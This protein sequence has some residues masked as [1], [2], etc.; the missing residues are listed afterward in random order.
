[1]SFARSLVL[2]VLISTL[3]V[4][5]AAAAQ[6]APERLTFT[7]RLVRSDGQPETGTHSLRFV[8]YDGPSSSAANLWEETR[9]VTI[10]N[11]Y[12]TV[13]LGAVALTPLSSVFTGPIRYLGLSLNQQ[14]EMQPRV[15]MLSTPYALHATRAVK[16]FDA[17]RATLA[18]AATTSTNATNAANADTLDT[19]DSSAFAL[20]GHGHAVATSTADG[21]MSAADKTKLDAVPT[22]WGN[23]LALNGTT[24]NVEYAGTGSA[25]T[26][27][28]SN[29]T[30]PLPTF[31][32]TQVTASAAINVGATATCATGDVVMGGGCTDLPTGSG[33]TLTTAPTATG[34]QCK[35]GGG[36]PPTSQV[37]ATAICCK[38]Q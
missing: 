22:A 37:T 27:A 25:N 24:V 10:S 38:L 1:M 20:S 14:S 33:F 12:Y 34:Y 21:F 26:V 3:L 36:T 17:D 23:G 28:R 15:A 31:A 2:P 5:S 4:S 13:D 7:G 35:A 18:D 32:C 11:G 9:M 16:A 6:D 8:I 19:L 29:H 30:H